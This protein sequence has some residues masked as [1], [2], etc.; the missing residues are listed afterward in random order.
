MKI[1]ILLCIQFILPV[2]LFAQQASSSNYNLM[3]YG[4]F[5]GHLTGNNEPAS[6]NYIAEV[7]TI[8]ARSEDKMESTSYDIYSG[9]VGLEF[10]ETPLPVVLSS[11]T[12]TL[13]NSKPRLNWITQTELGNAFW[14]VYR[15]ISQNLGQ[16]SILNIEPIEGAGTTSEPTEYNFTDHYG[17]EGGTTYWYWIESI[18]YDGV[19][20]I[21]GPIYLTIPPG[22]ND[23][24]TPQ[25][26]QHYGL[27][28]NFPN[29]FNP[30]TLISFGLKNACVGTLTIYNIKGQ[31]IKTLFMG[32]IPGNEVVSVV[33]NGR[34]DSG[35]EVTSGVYLYQLV[36]NT[37]EKYLMKMI[38]VK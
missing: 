14:N 21:Y 33:W 20:D 27:Y 9:F 25:I 2:L 22:I 37:K 29:P 23:P 17:I 16:A 28:Q 18:S 12:V 38:L 34:D 7:N 35:K 19:S 3:D 32:N 26:P 13:S 31:K 11:F 5:S 15:S 30:T 10:G 4:L 24:G 6:T 8:G 1:K 36:T